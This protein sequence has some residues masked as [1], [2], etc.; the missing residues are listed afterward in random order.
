MFGFS[1]MPK[2]ALVGYW[3]NW[4][5]LRLNEIND[6]YN[7]IQLA[8]ATTKIGSEYDMEFNITPI[9]NSV[10]DFILDLDFLHENNRKVILRIG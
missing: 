4:S 1:Q 5:D 8:F 6:S 9:Y 7:V 10:E 3:E 2:P